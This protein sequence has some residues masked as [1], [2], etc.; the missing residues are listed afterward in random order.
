MKFNAGRLSASFSCPQILHLMVII[1]NP[2][3]MTRTL[4]T[5]L[6]LAICTASH[7][8]ANE[9]NTFLI[10]AEV[11]AGVFHNSALTVEELDE[12]SSQGDSGHEFKAVL[13]TKWHITEGT[14]VATGYSYNQK[15]YNEYSE[16]DISLHQ[17]NLDV[18]HQF[19]SFAMG[20][21]V[22]GAKASLAGQTFLNYQQASVYV[23]TFLQPETYLRASLQTKNKRFERLPGRDAS[24]VGGH[25]D[26]F[27]FMNDANTMVMIG[28]N[29]ET[30]DAEEEQYHYS[31]IGLNTKITHKFDV[32]H[33]P[34]KAGLGV[35]YQHKD[36]QAVTYLSS[37][38]P[39]S[40]FQD[41]GT[42]F[43]RANTQ[44]QYAESVERDEYRT[45]VEADWQVNITDNLRL[46]AKF[47]YGDYHSLIASQTYQ[48][49]IT[50][51]RLNYRF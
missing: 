43:D 47:Q 12:V 46:T 37:E 32:F 25:I 40:P 44:E 30:E 14:K 3:T 28:L 10:D 45:L 19:D 50:S 21:R 18:T 23:G 33:L 39:N 11:G 31:S 26:L 8:V 29:A 7:A 13:N 41:A 35:R 24:G 36:Y 17:L 5:V 2:S 42:P 34:S 38:E 27:Y 16:Y 15:N 20:V 48:Q 49:N 6:C 51:L 4:S 22:D 9:Q 1:M